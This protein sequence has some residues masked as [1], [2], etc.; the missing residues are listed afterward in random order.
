MVLNAEPILAPRSDRPRD[1]APEWDAQKKGAHPKSRH[2]RISSTPNKAK[3]QESDRFK[4]HKTRYRGITYRLRVDESRV[5]SVYFKGRYRNV[6][7]GEREALALQAELRGKV[8]RG[9]R[10]IPTKVQFAEVAE[11]WFESK[12]KLRPWTRKGYRDF[13][14]RIL[15]PRFGMDNPFSIGIPFGFRSKTSK[16][17]IRKSRGRRSAKTARCK[18]DVNIDALMRKQ[19]TGPS[20]T[21][22]EILPT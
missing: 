15:L 16:H 20:Y 10:V 18:L 4:R 9:E 8:A 5:Y 7:G 17:V 11:Q 13:L 1:Q 6:E 21:A 19:R 22:F 2:R 3:A 12:R 14:D